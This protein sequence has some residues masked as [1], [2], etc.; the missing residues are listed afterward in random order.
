MVDPARAIIYSEIYEFQQN[1]LNLKNSDYEIC[2]NL[3]KEHLK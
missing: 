3:L 1:W 2:R